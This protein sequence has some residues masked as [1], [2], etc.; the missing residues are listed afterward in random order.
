MER[1][2]PTRRGGGAGVA[3]RARPPRVGGKL[4]TVSSPDDAERYRAVLGTDP[5]A[6]AAAD[7]SFLKTEPRDASRFH[8]SSSPTINNGRY[9][10]QVIPSAAKATL[11]VRL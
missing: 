3:Q 1:D 8:T 2:R 7:D 10:S 11:D 9:R 6:A 5:A 4:A